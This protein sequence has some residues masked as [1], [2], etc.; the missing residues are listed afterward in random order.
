MYRYILKRLLMT[1][2]VIFAASI[3]IFTIIYFVPGDPAKLLLGA[4]ATAEEVYAKRVALG[5]T[6]SYF[7][8]LGKFL[9]NAFIKFDLGTS[10]VLGESVVGS[11][12]KRLPYTIILG[13][14]SIVLSTIIAIPLGV[15]SAVHQNGI[16]DRLCM[17]VTMF[18]I[19]IPN[20]WLALM[21]VILFSQ[22][23]NLLPSFG[24]G[25]P[26]FYIMP[27][28]ANSLNTLGILAR[29][30]RSSVL[31]VYRADYIVTARA[32]GMKER[33]VIYKHML[34]NALIP[35]ITI[36]GGSLSMCITGTVIIEQV[37]SMP[38]VGTYLTGAVTSRDYPIVRGC[39]IILAA[40]TAIMMLLVDLA[41][42]V[43]DPRI[44]A[45]YIAQGKARQK[46]RQLKKEV[47]EG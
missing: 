3:L 9:Y 23:L 31:E 5:L 19:S 39:V 8:Q 33:L 6:D 47:R 26:E 22:K 4:T 46:K 37:F 11:L 16:Q 14:S 34:P 12:M 20:F 29:Q 18:C 44:K 43:V 1:V 40:F 41:Y 32:K 42:A 10:W 17:I 30:T 45:Q 25:G 2:V 24:V 15:T 36:V 35:V 27:I 7:V 13:V 21:M 38:G 28:I